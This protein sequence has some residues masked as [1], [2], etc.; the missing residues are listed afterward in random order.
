[1]T[2]TLENLSQNLQNATWL[3]PLI[4]LLAGILTSFSP[5]CLSTTSLTIAYIGGTTRDTKKAFKLSLILASGMAL[6]FFTMGMLAN[7]IGNIIKQNTS[8]WYF[9]SGI[10]MLLM[11]L[12]I[13]EIFE[14]IP[15][16]YLNSKNTKKGYIGAFIA[17]IFMGVFASP[18]ATPILILLLTMVANSDSFL[19]GCILLLFYSI[20]NGILTIIIGTFTGTMRKISHSEKYGIFS[21]VSKIVLGIIS[22]FFGLYMLYLAF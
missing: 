1:M 16:T 9:I 5:C 11:T 8:I 2:E 18:C 4:A 7:V 3:A 13:L 6:T 15:S 17:G 22:L 21:K 12:Q 20:G 14:F 19:K 10:L